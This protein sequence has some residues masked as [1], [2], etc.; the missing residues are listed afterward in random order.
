MSSNPAALQSVSSNTA[1]AQSVFLNPE[2]AL[3]M[4]PNPAA[5]QS[6][7][8]NP[9]A[10][11]SMTLQKLRAYL[12]HC[13]SSDHVPQPYSIALHWVYLPTL[14]QL[15][16]YHWY[17]H[18]PPNSHP[19]NPPLSFWPTWRCRI[20]TISQYLT[21]RVWKIMNLKMMKER[22]SHRRLWLYGGLLIG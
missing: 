15:R 2:A 11:Q 5:L 3:S 22:C 9:I 16:V 7:S 8:S 1:A 20:L 17:Q 12:Q 19:H 21:R 18:S 6:V 14:Q 13:S 4:S 10:A